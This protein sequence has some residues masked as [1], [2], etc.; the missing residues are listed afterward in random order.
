[1]HRMNL[2]DENLIID[3]PML[4][5]AA[6]VVVGGVGGSGTRVIAQLLQTIGFDMGSDL[7]ESIDDL[8][9]T[10]LFKRTDLWPLNQHIN[11]LTSAMRVYLTSR[12][13]LTPE[14]ISS[15]EHKQRTKNLVSDIYSTTPW[16]ETG[17]V[18]QRL[19]ALSNIAVKPNVW[20]WKEPNTHIVLPF[21]LSA[22]PNLSYIHVIRDG[23]DMAHSR[24]KNQLALWGPIL[25]GQSINESAPQTALDYWCAT[26]ERFL[27]IA[28]LHPG[29]VHT[30][31]LESCVEK[32]L[33]TLQ[34]LLRFIPGHIT[35]DAVATLEFKPK[36][37]KTSNRHL[38][39][40]QMS[41][42]PKQR[43]LLKKFGYQ[44]N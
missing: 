41:T 22:L 16:L 32:P 36:L 11:E 10:A 30:I 8:G 37:P 5:E 35:P 4:S 1:M 29:R 15:D 33:N 26:H 38:D 7:N 28:Q 34:E 21:L 17:T 40:D 18:E 31:T 12:G 24:N 13:I 42:T 39:Y 3:C 14:S 20:G 27:K 23:R 2:Y 44:E 43:K 25:L 9:F 6:P 19:E